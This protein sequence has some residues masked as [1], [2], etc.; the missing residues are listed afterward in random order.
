MN[1]EIHKSWENN[2]LENWNVW[3]FFQ[4]FQFSFFWKKEIQ[5]FLFAPLQSILSKWKWEWIW[6]QF[7]AVS[8]L[9][10]FERQVAFFFEIHYNTLRKKGKNWKFLSFSAMNCFSLCMYIMTALRFVSQLNLFYFSLFLQ[11]SFKMQ[12]LEKN[13]M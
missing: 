9:I 12:F 6:I 7:M 11:I 8:L 13:G 4:T 2:F 10:D 5:S 1:L 3:N